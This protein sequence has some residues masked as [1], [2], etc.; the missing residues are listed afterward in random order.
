MTPE[1][2]AKKYPNSPFAGPSITI[3]G[4]SCPAPPT[5]TDEQRAALIAEY[6]KAAAAAILTRVW[7]FTIRQCRE[8]FEREQ[9]AIRALQNAGIQILP[10]EEKPETPA[11]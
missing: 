11:I 2:Y 9:A 4:R 8:A 6:H 10:P 5:L 7:G 3:F 1:E